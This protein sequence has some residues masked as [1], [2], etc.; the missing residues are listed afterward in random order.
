MDF[1]PSFLHRLQF[2][3]TISFHIIFPTLTIGLA[4]GLAFVEYLYLKT[5]KPLYKEIYKM[6][7]KIFAVCFGMGVVSGIAMTYQFGTNWSVFAQKTGNIMGPLLSYEVLTA[8]F[9]ESS[10]LGIMLFGW[11]RV[12]PKMHFA[13]T[14]IVAIGTAISAFWIISANSWMQ[15]P[16]G[17]EVDAKGIFQPTS[18]MEIIFNPSFPYRLAHTLISAY[19]TS[20]FVVGGV[21]AYYFRKGKHLKH[22]Q[23]MLDMCM[24]VAAILAPLQFMVG[25]EHGENTLEHQPTKIAAME[26]HFERGTHRPLYLFGWPNNETET[27]DYAVG[28]P[29]LSSLIITGSPSGELPG[30]KDVPPTDR[31][32][33]PLVF[34]SFRFMIMIGVLMVFTSFLGVYYHFKRSLEKASLYH[35][36]CMLMGPSGILAVL[37]GWFVTEVGRQ[38]YTVYGIMRTSESFSSIAPAHLSASLLLFILVYSF[39]F[40]AGIYYIFKL[41]R[42]GPLIGKLEEEYYDHSIEAAAFAKKQKKEG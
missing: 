41:I 2:A 12:T 28:I 10:F 39:V 15:T 13:S 20:T 11:K 21:A 38:P 36:L 30:L 16:A 19:L 1:D 37:A 26:G 4:A 8:F 31:P 5:G 24:I 35:Y 17:F 34:W 7:V 25:H 3:F 27:L 32:P 22:A 29:G 14:V 40:G 42:K 23:K 18:W 6:W 9:L 33:L